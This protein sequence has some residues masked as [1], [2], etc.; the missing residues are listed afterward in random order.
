[1][2]HDQPSKGYE[3]LLSFAKCLHKPG[4]WLPPLVKL[5][6]LRSRKDRRKS[7]AA[8][9][10]MPLRL[11]HG[12]AHAHFWTGFRFQNEQGPDQQEATACKIRKGL[13]I[14]SKHNVSGP[15]LDPT[16]AVSLG[17]PEH[18]TKSMRPSPGGQK[19]GYHP[20]S[21]SRGRHIEQFWA[22][23]HGSEG[24]RT[25]LFLLSANLGRGRL[26]L[27][28]EPCRGLYFSNLQT[29]NCLCNQKK[30]SEKDPAKGGREKRANKDKIS[31]PGLKPTVVKPW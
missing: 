24:D 27:N 19:L 1:M 11:D 4:V 6:P 21:R 8:R 9:L 14:H 13:A 29:R 30:G 7:K 20:P 10:R 23:A 25:G 26:K 31:R 22:F 28:Q 17:W 18:T 15:A 12:M 3:E 5:Q 16:W 2:Q